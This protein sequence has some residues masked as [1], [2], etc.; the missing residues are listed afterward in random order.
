[1]K[2]EQ[3]DCTDWIVNF[4]FR[5]AEFHRTAF[6]IRCVSKIFHWFANSD[7]VDGAR[8]LLCSKSNQIW[9]II[10]SLSHFAC[11]HI[12]NELNFIASANNWLPLEWEIKRHKKHTLPP[13]AEYNVS[14]YTNLCVRREVKSGPFYFWSTS[15]IMPR[16]V[17]K[18]VSLYGRLISRKST[19]KIMVQMD[20]PFKW[21]K[22]KLVRKMAEITQA[23]RRTRTLTFIWGFYA[24][25]HGQLA[26]FTI[27]L[28]PA[29]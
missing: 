18:S 17:R 16:M 13:R 27:K 23:N 14:K 2:R 7:R 5:L 3:P 19:I 4:L 6:V 15:I 12:K 25:D 20:A 10:R 21:T 9:A 1:M 26:I 28:L 8:R 22:Q 11:A 29:I 24:V